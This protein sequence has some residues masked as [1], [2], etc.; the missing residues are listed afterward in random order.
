MRTQVGPLEN[1][2]VANSATSKAWRGFKERL[3]GSR[4]WAGSTSILQ[5][6]SQLLF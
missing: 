1:S 4:R 5:G 6:Q 2:K 3:L